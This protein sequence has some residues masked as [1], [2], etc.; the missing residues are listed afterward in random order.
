[1]TGAISARWYFITTAELR[2]RGATSA[3]ALARAGDKGGPQ[4]GKH[5]AMARR[6]TM[7]SRFAGDGRRRRCVRPDGRV[8]QQPS[9]EGLPGLAQIDKF[10][11]EQ[12]PIP[13][14]A[15]TLRNLVKRGLVATASDKKQGQA[16]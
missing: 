5:S 14:I 8:S 3:N 1:M 4:W 13:T 15:E 9:K 11:R 7:F 12:D 6:A 16:A 2:R 10:R